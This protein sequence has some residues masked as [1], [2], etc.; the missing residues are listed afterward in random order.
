[1]RILF[2]LL[3]ILVAGIGT[4]TLAYPAVA[5]VACPSCYGFADLGGNIYVADDTLPSRRSITVSI[6]SRAR[7]RVR[8]FYGEVRSNP[9]VMVCLSNSCY[10]RFGG[11][12]RG[13]ALLDQA[14]FLSPEGDD[15]VVAAH[16]LSHI[17]LHNRIGLE[18]T[19]VKAIPQWFDEGLA[20][21]VSND[22][23]YLK[24][25]G[26]ADRCLIE[27]DGIMP[28]TRAAWIENAASRGLYAK[29]ACKVSRW[30]KNHGGPSG[31]IKLADAIAK[32]EGFVEASR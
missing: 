17:E 3:A 1:M 4:I 28:T 31:I 5:A 11:K 29:A 14:L 30:L 27:P 20:V 21:Y 25:K 16:E 10:S 19:V 9:R 2:G 15:L 7:Q 13:I 12:S 6:I 23:R 26:A 18:K 8:D 22:P 32:G 24:P